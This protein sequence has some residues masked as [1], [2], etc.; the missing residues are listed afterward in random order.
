MDVTDTA[1]SHICSEYIARIDPK[2]DKITVEP[3]AHHI[4]CETTGKILGYRDLVKMDVSVLKIIMCKKIGRLSQGWMEHSGTDIIEY[5]FHKE[6]PKDIKATYVRSVCDIR[7]Q[8]TEAHITRLTAGGNLIDYPGEVS[9]PT[10]DLT[11]MELH[12][13]STISDIKSRYMCMDVKYF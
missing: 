5:I 8:K 13:N 7:P 6:K 3:L 4:H 2:K 9:K 11:T 1:K 12:A 10:S